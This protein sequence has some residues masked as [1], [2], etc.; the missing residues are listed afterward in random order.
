MGYKEITIQ[1]AH[2][3]FGEYQAGEGNGDTWADENDLIDAM[4]D[5][6][7]PADMYELGSDELPDG[8]EDI[9]GRIHN[10]PARVFAI[11]DAEAGWRY[12]GVIEIEEP[13]E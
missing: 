7:A 1:P 10:E 6:V 13:T 8:C 9:R 3:G 11:G 4:R 5:G 2:G 12:V